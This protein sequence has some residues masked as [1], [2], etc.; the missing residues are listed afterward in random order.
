VAQE[1][2]GKEKKQ[3][4]KGSEKKVKTYEK[5]VDD[6]GGQRGDTARGQNNRTRFLWGRVSRK[7]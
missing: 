5:G 7:G 3:T 6:L 2:L 1:G 4:L